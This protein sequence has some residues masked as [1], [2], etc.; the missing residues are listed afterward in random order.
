MARNWTTSTAWVAA[1][2]AAGAIACQRGPTPEQLAIMAQKDSLVQEI[3]EQSRVMSDISAELAKVQVQGRALAIKSESPRTALRD[4]IFAR[5]SYVTGRLASAEKQLR[6]SRQRISSITKL[7]DSLKATLEFTISNYESTIA[8]QKTTLDELNAQ[9]QK[10]AAENADL[11]VAKVAL[12]D[13]VR[14]LAQQNST[15]YYVVGT[16]D[17]LLKR[18]IIREEGGS[19]VLFV[20]GKAGKTIVPARDLE[21]SEFTPIDKHQ[22]TEIPLPQDAEYRFAS[23]QNLDALATPPDTRGRIKGSVLKIA[24]PDKFWVGSRFLIIVRG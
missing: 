23:Q 10:L 2:V 11:T 22:V 6:S 3:A 13:T 9:V 16:K 18:G 19:R 5:I 14:T 20:F 15:V 7:S 4:T 1:A 21:P 12:T 8:S 17:D 24:E